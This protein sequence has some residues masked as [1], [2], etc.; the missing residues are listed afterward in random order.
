MTDRTFQTEFPDFHAGDLPE[1]PAG[2][3]DV[4]WRN[5]ACPSFENE[6]LGLILIIDFPRPED[7][8][9]PEAPRFQLCDRET[10]EGLQTDDFAAILAAASTVAALHAM[11]ATA[12]NDWYLQEVGYR[13]Q[14]DCPTMT[15]QEL[16]DLCKE[17]ALAS[18]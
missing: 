10:Y 14:V 16:R 7:R 4:S 11:T 3:A 15:E 18:D 6:D 1:I 5:D 8:E 12:L 2:F 9:F 17:Y 13:P